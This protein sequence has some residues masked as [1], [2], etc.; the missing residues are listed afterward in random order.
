MA[1]TQE[2]S[3]QTAPADLIDH[4]LVEVAMDAGVL[5]EKKPAKTPD[6]KEVPGLFNAWITLNNPSQFNSYTTEMVKSVILA[7]RAASNARDVV[8]V[9]F[10]GTGDRAFCTGGNTKEYA[11]YYAGNPHEY[12]QYMRLFND[13]VSSI[14]SCDK[15]VIC[16]VNGMRIGGGQEIGMACDFTITHDLANFGQAGPKHGSAAIGG[17][18]DFLPLMIGAEQAMVSGTLC[19]PFSAHKAYRLG[20]ASGLVPALKVD[21]EFVANPMVITDQFLDEYGRIVHGEFKIGAEFGAGKVVFKSGEMDLSLLDEAVEAMCAKLLL[22]FP[23]CMTKSL[24]ELRKPKLEAWNRNHEDS[25]AW[26]ALNMMTEARAGFRA[27]NEGTRETGR[28]I[29]F[30]ELRQALAKGT[31]WTRDLTQSLM[32]GQKSEADS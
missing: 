16:R 5:F 22:T 21:G 17:A 24:E 15:P 9:V 8:C 27:F 3:T 10:T 25:R 4:N 28:E 13:M 32:P 23:D 14:L 11:E 30:V 19:E 2:I 7:F 1:T 18:T 20:I 29:D 6:G 31:P 12:R 26:L